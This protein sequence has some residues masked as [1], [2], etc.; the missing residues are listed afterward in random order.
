MTMEPS[1][2]DPIGP[3]AADGDSFARWSAWSRELALLAMTI[4]IVVLFSILYP[5]SFR[6]TGN[7]QAVL[8]NLA[9]EGI[10]SL[11]MMLLMIAGTFDLSVGALASLSGV[12]AGWLMKYANWPV[13]AAVAASLAI[14]TACG[15]LNGVFVAKMRV[16]ALI[17]TLGTMGI[18]QGAA[19]L[20][21][22]PGI[23]FLPESFSRFGQSEWLGVQAPV[24]LLA[25]MAGCAH[26]LL[27]RT[28][29]FRQFYYIGSNAKA[30]RLSG[31]PVQRLQITAFAIMGLIAGIA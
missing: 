20:I 15:T 4:F 2:A 29:F 27:A 13:P 16:N 3:V 8:R 19:L 17:T 9:F 24:W 30:A 6:S 25:A 23:T 11:G 21:G 12:V 18:F 28:R 7:L 26:F 22:G 31:M 10:L 1:G 5:Y 14:A